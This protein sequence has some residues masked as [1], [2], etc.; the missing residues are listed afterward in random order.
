VKVSPLLARPMKSL[1]KNQNTPHN[2]ESKRQE[3][4]RFQQI[5]PPDLSFA[6]F[7]ALFS[8]NRTNQ[9][10]FHVQQEV[11][12]LRACAPQSGI[13]EQSELFCPNPLGPK[14]FVW[15]ASITVAPQLTLAQT[16]HGNVRIQARYSR[17][18]IR[19]PS[20]L[21]S[22]LA[23]IRVHDAAFANT[24]TFGLM[25]DGWYPFVTA[26]PVTVDQPSNGTTLHPETIDD[27]SFSGAA[28]EDLIVQVNSSYSNGPCF[29]LD[30]PAGVAVGNGCGSSWPFSIFQVMSEFKALPATGIYVIRVYSAGFGETG[31]YSLLTQCVAGCP[32]TPNIS[33]LNPTWATAGGAGFTLTINGSGFVPGANVQW[34]GS[35]LVTTYASANQLTAAVPTGL[36]TEASSASVVVVNPDGLESNPATFTINQPLR[37]ISMSPCRVVDTRDPTKPADF[38]PPSF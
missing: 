23:K 20:R 26:S 2:Q 4:K 17:A 8:A 1:P 7:S 12:L 25:L 14:I 11:G 5:Q 29:I 27:W 38:G 24:G 13:T 31:T 30:G 6:L 15:A 3:R 21:G 19:T 10:S 16:T 34:N 22:H 33:S 9:P 32:T 35:A 37:F 28:G 36:I 18:S